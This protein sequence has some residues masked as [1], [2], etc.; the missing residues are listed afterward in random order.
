M[1]EGINAIDDESG[2]QEGE[3]GQDDGERTDGFISVG[4]QLEID[5]GV[6]HR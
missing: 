5:S 6:T 3:Q 1:G 2:C 4:Q